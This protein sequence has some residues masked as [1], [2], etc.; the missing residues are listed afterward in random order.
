V[1]LAS[2]WLEKD[3]LV[4][5]EAHSEQDDITYNSSGS[6]RLG[7]FKTIVLMNSGSASASEILAG[8]L[9]DNGKAILVGE[10]SFG[11]GSVQ[12]LVPLGDNMAVK[13]TIAKWIT[14]NGRNINKEGIEPDLK[15]DRTTEDIAANRDPQMDQALQEAAK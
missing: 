11:K 6:N 1:A 10:R 15:V 12:E 13:V 8:A 3:K 4:V 5:K 7:K 14:P 9:K 2:D